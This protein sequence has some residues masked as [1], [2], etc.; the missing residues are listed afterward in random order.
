MHISQGLRH[1]LVALR[2]RHGFVCLLSFFLYSRAGVDPVLLPHPSFGFLCFLS[3]TLSHD[4]R[5]HDSD[6]GD[7]MIRT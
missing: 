4:K 2:D 6:C 7:Y 5:S 3:F 1:I